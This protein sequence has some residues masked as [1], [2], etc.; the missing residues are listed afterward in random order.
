M[1]PTDARGT[2]HR[3]CDDRSKLRI[4]S[5]VPSLTELLCDLG[6]AHA[7][8]GRTGYCIHPADEVERIT[9]VG[10][11]KSVNVEK[12]RK[13]APTHLIV[14]IDENQKPTID[15]LEP[16]VPHV[17]V[18]HPQKP[19]DNLGLY[20][21]FGHV[22]ACEREA[23][24]LC[25]RFEA[26]WSALEQAREIGRWPQRRVLYLI[27]KDPWMT[28]ARDTYIAA[29]LATV[30]WEQI[31]ARDALDDT[32]KS[33][34]RYPA[35]DLQRAASTAELVLLSSEPYDFGEADVESLSGIASHVRL[36]DGEM[37]SW[38]GSRRDRRTRL[39]RQA[40]VRDRVVTHST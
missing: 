31:D 1:T 34:P 7:I 20:R 19:R 13:L 3:R 40:G 10:G 29:L 18:T 25:T 30:G 36:V 4:V 5:L 2:P 9:K 12:I 11:T 32:A 16:F 37:L 26:A 23:D 35:I 38:Y 8:V 15:A 17:I 39:P 14:N 6:L 27:W 22:F 28:I 24:L 21:L 33:S